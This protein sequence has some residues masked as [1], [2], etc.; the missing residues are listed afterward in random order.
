MVRVLCALTAAA[1]LAACTTQSKRSE[2]ELAQLLAWLPGRYDNVA[3]SEADAHAGRESHVAL[4]LNIVR[5]YAPLM[6]DYAF[7]VQETA[8][9]DPR[10]VIAQ[11]AVAFAVVK[12]R[13]IVESLWSFA[14]PTRW[15]DAHL[16]LDLFKGLMPQDFVPLAGCDLIW[17]KKEGRFVG[18]NDPDTCR[19]SSSAGGPLRMNLRAELTADELAVA[20]QSYESSGRVVQGNAAEP[21]YRFRR[22]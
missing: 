4:E 11:H 19:A 16:N 20:E 7:Y 12:D 2:A 22:R 18:A 3:Q 6:G 13:G 5:I 17:T 15:R 14:E 8:A 21:F 9:D 1:L 10:R